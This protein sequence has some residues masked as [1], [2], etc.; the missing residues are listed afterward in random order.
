[1][2][3]EASNADVEREFYPCQVMAE[4]AAPHKTLRQTTGMLNGT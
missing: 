2:Q 4:Q 1:M 3:P